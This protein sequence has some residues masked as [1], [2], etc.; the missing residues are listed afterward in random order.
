[1]NRRILKK[2]CKR[3]VEILVAHHGYRA[4]DFAPAT[5]DETID[6]P[7]GM[8][9]R[10]VRRGFLEPGPLAGTPLYWSHDYWSQDA[11]AYLPT[12]VLEDILGAA[13]IRYPKDTA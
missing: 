12:H 11:D 7:I 10:A 8:E 2:Q 1:M 3:A 9:R 13:F 4:R 6:A 5:G